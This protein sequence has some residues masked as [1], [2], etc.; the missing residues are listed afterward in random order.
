M[1]TVLIVDTDSSSRRALEAQLMESNQF[2]QVLACAALTDAVRLISLHDVKV[3][4]LDADTARSSDAVPMIKLVNP[5]MGV[6]LIQGKNGVLAQSVL[7]ELGAHAQ[8]SRLDA[9]IDIIASVAKALVVRL[10]PSGR[11]LGKFLKDSK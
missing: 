9:T 4:L 8:T 7:R 5:D 2:E 11:L 1:T 10:R 3:V 6:V